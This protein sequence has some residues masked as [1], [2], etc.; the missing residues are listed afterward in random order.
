MCSASPQPSVELPV[1]NMRFKRKGEKRVWKRYAQFSQDGTVATLGPATAVYKHGKLTVQCSHDCSV[2][3]EGL[4][5]QL[6]EAGATVTFAVTE[7]SPALKVHPLECNMIQTAVPTARGDPAHFPM[8]SLE[9]GAY[10]LIFP[11]GRKKHKYVAVRAHAEGKLSLGAL[12]WKTPLEARTD[13]AK[14]LGVPLHGVA[15]WVSGGTGMI[16]KRLSEFSWQAFCSRPAPVQDDEPP[17]KRRKTVLHTNTTETLCYEPEGAHD[18]ATATA[19][20]ITGPYTIQEGD[21]SV[22]Q[23]G[24]ATFR[25]SLR[26]A[27]KGHEKSP[28]DGWHTVQFRMRCPGAPDHLQSVRIPWLERGTL[29]DAAR[30]PSKYFGGKDFKLARGSLLNSMDDLFICIVAEMDSKFYTVHFSRAGP[31]D[32]IPGHVVDAM[33]KL[34]RCHP[35]SRLLF[36]GR[37]SRH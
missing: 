21:K 11:L 29:L 30:G 35:A 20:V 6:C 19:Q 10:W 8:L 22:V 23:K 14:R 31:G 7:G 24:V 3:V 33:Y 5:R 4:S 15:R 13:L 34:C 37:G 32:A 25:F 1:N 18:G 9:S 28:S 2:L 27:P 26:Y 17:A 16:G 36:V 12:S